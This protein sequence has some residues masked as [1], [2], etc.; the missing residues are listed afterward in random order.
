MARPRFILPEVTWPTA[1]EAMGARLFAPGNFGPVSTRTRTWI[2]AMVP[3]RSNDDGEVTDDVLDWYG[4]FAE[5]RPGVLV[6]EATGIRDIPSGPLLRIGSDKYIP[7]LTK[8]AETVRERSSGQTRL[9][10][11]L[12]DFV[13]IRR[14]PDPEKF[15][16]RFLQITDSHRE[17]M[18]AQWDEPGLAKLEITSEADLR[19]ALHERYTD[20]PSQVHAVLTTRE[21]EDLEHGHRERITDTQ[22][23][24]IAELP[25][26]LPTLF[27]A[28]AKRAELAGFDGAELHYAHAY[29]MASFLSATNDRKDGYGSTLEGRLRLPL[30][31]F[32]AAKAQVSE[33]FALGCRML[34]DEVIEGGTGVQEAAKIATAFAA[35]G[36]D[37]ISLSK[38]GKF[39]DARQPKVG[40]AAYPY[41]GKSGHECMPTIFIEDPAIPGNIGP[42]GRNLP[43]AKQIRSAIRDAGHQTPVVAAGGINDFAAAESALRSETCDFVGSAR[44]AIADPDW[45]RKVEQGDGHTIRR[46]KLT[47]YCEA[48]DERHKQVTCQLWDRNFSVP[49]PGGESTADIELSH[50]GR[51]RL[52]APASFCELDD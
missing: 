35:A 27:A 49:D 13:G 38:G 4:R 16:Q 9:L 29:T 50:D 39:D 41:T 28:A 24:H 3:W 40:S 32:A 52:I 2:P 1:L 14:R 20:L 7:G 23:E 37:F 6:V 19:N 25:Q 43:L 17:K 42:F 48:L 44:Q 36:M 34:S 31:V 47:N 21:V 46:C 5:G 22:L 18:A 33:R 15:F 12:I 11:Q 51:R 45:F 10:I 8:L 26:V 30:E